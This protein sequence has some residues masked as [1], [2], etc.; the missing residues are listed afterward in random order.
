MRQKT[1]ELM[2]AAMSRLNGYL[3]GFHYMQVRD[4]EI[5]WESH[6]TFIFAEPIAKAA[7]SKAAT[8]KAKPAGRTATPTAQPA[9]LNDDRR[10][11]P[12]H[13]QGDSKGAKGQ[14]ERGGGQ[15]EG[16][17]VVRATCGATGHRQNARARAA[18]SRIE[19][20]RIV[21]GRAVV[22]R[23]ATARTVAD[24]VSAT[25]RRVATALAIA[26]ATENPLR[27]VTLP[28]RLSVL[29]ALVI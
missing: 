18:A 28:F 22:S 27:S 7:T 20:G 17:R 21:I 2:I 26:D 19:I 13:G 16:S 11:R 25:I 4:T 3:A 10:V 24:R 15:P 29:P 9:D 6:R 12:R 5:D 1:I 8:S 14:E 23:T